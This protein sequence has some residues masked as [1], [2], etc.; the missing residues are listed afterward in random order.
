M[1]GERTKLTQVYAYNVKYLND[2]LY[3]CCCFVLLLFFVVVVLYCLV[4]AAASVWPRRPTFCAIELKCD[5][6][7]AGCVCG[8][9]CVHVRAV[10]VVVIIVV[11]F[12][13]FHIKYV[14]AVVIV[15]DPM[16]FIWRPKTD[17]LLQRLCCY[18]TKCNSLTRV[19]ALSLSF[20]VTVFMGMCVRVCESVCLLYRLLCFGLVCSFY[21]HAIVFSI[22]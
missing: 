4:A 21:P 6:T 20:S 8:G 16:N 3:C 7:S 15:M 2:M 22:Y 13:Y 19:S 10:F 18:A 11:R 5:D 14:A 1:Q 17:T 12:L 9:V